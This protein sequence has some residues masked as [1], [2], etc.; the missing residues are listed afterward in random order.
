MI[1]RKNRIIRTFIVLL[2]GLLLLLSVPFSSMAAYLIT[3]SVYWQLNDALPGPI[4]DDLG[5]VNGSCGTCPTTISPGQINDA[6]DFA[7]G[8]VGVVFPANAI[9]DFAAGTGF[10]IE[11]WTKISSTPGSRQVMIG[12]IDSTNSTHWWLSAEDDGTVGAYFVDSDGTTTSPVTFTS[13]SRV[14]DGTWHHVVLVFDADNEQALLYIDGTLETT[15]PQ[16]ADNLDGFASTRTVTLGYHNLAGFNFTGMLDNVAIYSATALSAD[17]VLQNYLTGANRYAL[18]ED[19]APVFNGSRSETAAVGFNATFTATGVANPPVTGYSSSDLPTGATINGSTG[20]INWLPSDLQSGTNDFTVTASNGTGSGDQDWSVEV[21]DLCLSA[22][23]GHWKLEEDG[24]PFVDDT[25]VISDATC[26]TCPTR[27]TGKVG[28]GQ[29]FTGNNGQIDIPDSAVFDWSAS[30]SF[31]IELWMKIAAAPLSRQVMIGRTAAGASFWWVSVETDGSIGAQFVDSGGGATTTITTSSDITDDSWHHVVVILDRDA[32][33]GGQI[34]IYVDGVLEGTQDLTAVN[35]G[36][37]GSASDV[38]L[39][40]FNSGG[41]F[42][43]EGS[44]DEVAIYNMALT[45]TMIRQHLSADV[46]RYYCNGS[47]TITS[48]AGTEAT[49]EQEYTYTATATDPE[50]DTVTWSLTTSP[51]GMTIDGATGAVAWTPAVGVASGNVSI[52]ATDAYGATAIQSYTITVDSAGGGSGGGGG[53]GGGGCF[54][55]TAQN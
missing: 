52:L 29:S 23:D 10:S 12:R 46:G 20:V 37:F 34:L 18:A 47:P 22:L 32:G 27:V 16:N 26:T 13:T 40:Y 14:D 15:K 43:F 21:T 44:L 5:V 33:A 51:A 38:T 45:T 8:N 2:T 39:G 4:S 30:A 48:T 50:G 41:F 19:F 11:L 31:S 7:A 25:G 3:P 54:I 9:F 49:E 55:N 42:R 35:D 36:D 28:F 1:G 6:F 24:G 53:G 17:D